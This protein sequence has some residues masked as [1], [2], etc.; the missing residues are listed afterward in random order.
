MLLDSR[1]AVSAGGSSRRDHRQTSGEIGYFQRAFRVYDRWGE[2][3]A[4]RHLARALPLVAGLSHRKKQ[5]A[6]ITAMSAPCP[7]HERSAIDMR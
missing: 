6:G 2:P 7:G 4:G 1:A 3:D 5:T